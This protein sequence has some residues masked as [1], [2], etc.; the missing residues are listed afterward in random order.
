M[1]SVKMGELIEYLVA[2]KSKKDRISERYAQ[3][4][5]ARGPIDSESLYGVP[6]KFL[7]STYLEFRLFIDQIDDC[8]SLV[9]F[10]IGF[11]VL[12]SLNIIAASGTLNSMRMQS[13]FLVLGFVLANSS[14]VGAGFFQSQ[15]SKLYAPIHSLLTACL[16]GD[17]K[18][19]H[20][21][22][23]WRRSLIDLCGARSKLYF[24]VYSFNISYALALEVS[25]PGVQEGKYNILASLRLT[26]A[27]TNLTVQFEH[28]QSLHD[29]IGSGEMGVASLNQRDLSGFR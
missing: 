6:Q 3:K 16:K 7:T 8:R 19:R 21:A 23:L 18:V 14:L 11:T 1:C 28:F 26:L 12:H 13:V 17:K 22:S 27:P 20:L 10:L 25:K 9:N 29:H 5:I 4:V 15:S 2:N 24:R